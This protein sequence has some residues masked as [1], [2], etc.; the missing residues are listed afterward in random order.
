MITRRVC[1]GLL[2]SSCLACEDEAPRPPDTAPRQPP[3]PT[4]RRSAPSA[5]AQVTPTTTPTPSAAPVAST[6]KRDLDQSCG[7]APTDAPPLDI[8]KFTLTSKLENRKPTDEL[9]MVK[10]G[11]KIYAYLVVKN[12]TK[13]ERCLLVTFRVNGRKRASLTLDVGTSPT[14]RT[15]AHISPSKG[16]APGTVEV[17]V[18][19][20]QGRQRYLQKV[21]VEPESGAP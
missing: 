15:W 5:S 10:P 7:T 4:A 6:K 21:L 17:E 19:D 12:L 18:T 14:W 1:L 8:V 20:D 13:E 2:A 9:T 3:K 11:T 16:D